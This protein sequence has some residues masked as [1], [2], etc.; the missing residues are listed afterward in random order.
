[1]YCGKTSELIRRIQRCVIAHQPVQVF[2]P[3]MDWRFGADRIISHSKTDLEVATNIKP[4]PVSETD[5]FRIRDD[6]RVVAFDEAQFFDEK[7]IIPVVTSLVSDGIRVVCAGLD[8]NSYGEPFGSM[9]SLLAL[10]DEIT[11]LKSVC[12]VCHEDGNRTHRE[13]PFSSN[14]GVEVGGQGLYEPRCL[15][16]WKPTPKT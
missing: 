16:C 6:T 8:L 2:K 7:W 13:I 1:M 10:A 14:T 12:V 15:Q 4:T 9:P 5:N 11:K 3:K